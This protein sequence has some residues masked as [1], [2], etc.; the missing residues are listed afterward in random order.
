VPE[1][2]SRMTPAER[3]ARALIA[4]GCFEQLLDFEHRGKKVH[5]SRLGYRITTRFVRI[6]FG[7]LFPHPHVVFTDEMLRPEQ[8]DMDIFADGVDTI[9]TTHQR[10]AESYFADGSIA[11]ACP[12]LQALLEIMAKGQT[13]AGHGLDAPEVRSLFTR[14]HLEGSDWYRARLDT[15][16]ANEAKLWAHHVQSLEAV[17]DQD[18]YADVI[19][20]L[21][22]KD[23]LFNAKAELAR[24]QSP[25]YR[26]SL[27][28]TLGVQPLG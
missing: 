6:Y 10:V 21:G 1:I 20:R 25:A 19:V 8:Q 22:L 5:A 4:D 24:V 7:R 11:W 15:K 12:P 14:E 9:V 3:S 23:R 26:Q 17:L 18:H 27:E 28:G 13:A 16:Q 2:F